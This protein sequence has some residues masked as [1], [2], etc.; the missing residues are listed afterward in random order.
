MNSHARQIMFCAICNASSGRCSEDCGFCT[1]SAHH[2]ITIE[3]YDRKEIAA[4]VGE[5]NEA[6]KNKAAG[7]C[8]VT[9]GKALDPKKLAYI[10]EAAKAVKDAQPE[11]MLIACCGLA[12][13]T[14][15][16]SLKESG[17]DIY[18][19]NIETARSFYPS[20]CTTMSWQERFD[21]N[22][23]A[24]N[25]GLML[26][27]GGIFGLGET[28]DQRKEMLQ[29]L[30]SLEPMSTPLNFYH[31]HPDLPI[32]RELMPVD[33]A[34]EC[35]ALTRK[36]LPLTRIMIAGGREVTFQERQPEMFEA[37]ADAIVVGNYLTTTG[38]TPQ[39][40][41]EMVENAGYQILSHCH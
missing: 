14:A 27:T 28:W 1:Q 15:L 9:S 4:I 19:H 31:P 16:E 13:D 29:S 23:R 35:I 3:S 39:D 2:G 12:D 38:R 18:N 33:E 25:A 34:L 5:V 41:I 10:T 30:A 8:L 22:T 37:G 7:F 17:V 24:Q 20:A 6:V 40:D 32:K 21:T 11:I 26:C 36:M